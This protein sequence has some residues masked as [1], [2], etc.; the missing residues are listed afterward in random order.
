MKIKAEEKNIKIL[1]VPE[2]KEKEQTWEHTEEI[3]KSLSHDKLGS[4]EDFQLERCHRV[5]N[6]NKA[7]S[8]QRNGGRNRTGPIVAK[9]LKWKEKESVLGLARTK[10][11]EGIRLVQDLSG[12]T[13]ARRKEKIPQLV[14]ARAKGKIAYFVMDRLVIRNPLSHKIKKCHQCK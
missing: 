11:P 14:E 3:V 9:F 5:G 7:N 8:Q 12:K 2:D 10:K 4:S 1:G 13:L 6:A